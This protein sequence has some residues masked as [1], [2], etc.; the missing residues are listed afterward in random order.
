MITY[1]DGV[2]PEVLPH[3]IGLDTSSQIWNSIVNLY[4]SKTTSRLMFY[5][6][7]LH[8]QRKGDMSMKEFLLKIKSYSDS[9]ASCGE[10][11]S[12]HEHIIAIL[13]RLS[14]EYEP[15]VSFILAGQHAYTVQGVTT[16]LLDAEARQQV[17]LAETPS[18]ANL[19]SQQPA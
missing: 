2:L 17:I 7:A 10:A 18:S 8:S 16:M 13:N 6:R 9:L 11:I 4:G 14:F 5:H 12:A 15:I 19:V 1:D 3:L